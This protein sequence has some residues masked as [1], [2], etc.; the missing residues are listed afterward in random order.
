MLRSVFEKIISKKKNKIFKFDESLKTV[1]L[2]MFLMQKVFELIRGFKIILYLK[3]PTTLFLGRNVRFFCT[4][5]IV[6]G[7]FVS[8]AD[9]CYLSGMGK[10]KLILGNGVSIGAFSRLVVSTTFN[11]LGSHIHIGNNVGIGEYSRVGGSGGVEIGDDTII[12]QYFSAHPENHV[13]EDTDTL[14]RHQGTTRKKIVIGKNC[15][16]GS[17]VTVLS[18]VIIGDNSIVGA[19]S[20]VTKDIPPDSIAAGNPAKVIRSR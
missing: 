16:L 14:I 3:K 7:N 6:F 18:G 11:N 19:G 20:I 4:S 15:W 5:N 12:A 17:K 2:I 9:Y 10:G 8:L 13:I 1:T